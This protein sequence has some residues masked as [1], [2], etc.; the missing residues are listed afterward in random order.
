VVICPKRP[1][2]SGTFRTRTVKEVP[3]LHNYLDV[4]HVLANAA[5]SSVR[6]HVDAWFVSSVLFSL[7]GASCCAFTCLEGL[8]SRELTSGEEANCQAEVL[9]DPNLFDQHCILSDQCSR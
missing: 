8:R 3:T 6:Y 1:R 5:K 7:L 9:P 2:V 4:L